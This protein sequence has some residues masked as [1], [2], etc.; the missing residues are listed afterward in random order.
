MNQTELVE[1]MK[2]IELDENKTY[3][4][5]EVVEL[6]QKTLD[7]VKDNSKYCPLQFSPSDVYWVLRDMLSYLNRNVPGEFAL[8]TLSKGSYRVQFRTEEVQQQKAS[9]QLKKDVMK[10]ADY[11]EKLTGRRPTWG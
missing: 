5:A 8:R 2:Q 10:T 6:V 9:R 7:S 11:L 4:L 1:E 3:T